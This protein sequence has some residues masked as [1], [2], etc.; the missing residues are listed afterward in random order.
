ML[1]WVVCASPAYLAEAGKPSCPEQLAAHRCLLHANVMPNDR[2]WRFEPAGGRHAGRGVTVKV[3]GNLEGQIAA[4]FVMVVAAAEV[5]V[6]APVEAAEPVV[7][8]EA[9]AKKPRRSRAKKTDEP[10]AENA[11][12]EEAPAKPARASRARKPA[13]K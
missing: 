3:N 11:P 5:V 2:L 12:V 1:D 8:E 7:Q 9:P 13:A 6:E 10:A 4:F